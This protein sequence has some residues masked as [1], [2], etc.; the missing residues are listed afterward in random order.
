MVKNIAYDAF[1]C[2]DV[3]SELHLHHPDRRALG[4]QQQDATW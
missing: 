3:G 2:V 1:S 4:S